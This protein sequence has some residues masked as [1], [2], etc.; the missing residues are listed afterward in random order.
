VGDNVITLVM[1]STQAWV[2]HLMYD[3]ISFE[4]EIPN[5]KPVLTLSKQDVRCHGGADGS[6]TA[7]VGNGTPPYQLKLDNGTYA[8]QLSPFTF[9]NL[10]VGNYTVYVRDSLNEADTMVIT[11]AEPTALVLS[12]AGANVTCHGGTDGS[13]TA[14]FSG[15][16]APYYVKLHTDSAYSLQTAPYLFDQLRAGNYIVFVRD[17]NGCEIT[18]TVSIYEPGAAPGPI[19]KWLSKPQ[20]LPNPSHYQFLLIMLGEFEYNLF[21]LLGKPLQQGRGANVLRFGGNLRPGIYLLQVKAGSKTYV[22]RVVKL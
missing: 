13:I 9:N 1:A 15:G 20:V 11:V 14:S 18:D 16:T 17:S 10:A 4:G 3:Y 6:V 21:D 19:V 7:S 22:V 8:T 2:N 12:T 5:P